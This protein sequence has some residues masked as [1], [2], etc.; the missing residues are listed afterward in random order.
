VRK[1]AVLTSGGD[2]PGMNAAVRAVVL[3][4]ERANI[5]VIGYKYGYNGLLENNWVSLCARR[6]HNLIQRGGT[7]LH[8]GRCLEFKTEDSAKTAAKHLNEEEIEGLVV[9]GGDG[10]FRGAEHLSQYWQGNIVG[11][12]GT[13]DNDIAGTDASIGFYTA[14]QTAVDSIDKVRDTADAFER[15]FVVE[16]MGRHAGF[17]ALNAAVASASNYA[18]LPELFQNEASCIRDI[19]HQVRTRSETVGHDSFIIV[20]AE[21]VWPDGLDDLSTRLADS[22]SLEVKQVTLGHV[23]RGGSPTPEDRM[24]ATKLGVYAVER[25]IHGETNIM[26]GEQKGVLCQHPLSYAWK[27]QKQIAV[28]DINILNNLLNDRFARPS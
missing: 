4:C 13:I 9:I 14:V 5:T 17:L 1:I 28:D 7:Y 8:S 10:S 12:P 11:I 22:L 20:V 21:N 27:N 18:V 25:L 6:V 19:V 24:L 2:A 3:A 16:V 26:L 15:V 23:Q